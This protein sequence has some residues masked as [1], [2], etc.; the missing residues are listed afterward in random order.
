MKVRVASAGTGKTASLV[1]RYL[2][3]IAAG[4][5]LRRIAGVT[6]T[7]KAADELQVRVGWAMDEVLATGKHLSFRADDFEQERFLEAQRE[8]SG[9][10]ISTIHGFM[11][12]C[13]RLAAPILH[14]DP[15]FSMLGDWEARALF[16]EEW[17][18]LRYLAA[19]PSHPLHTVASE[20]LTEP[21]LHLFGKRSLVEQYQAAEGE[22]NEVLLKVYQTVYSAYEARLGG[23]LLSP[24]EVERR[25]IELTRKPKAMERVLER[26]HILL[27]DEYQDV[28]PLQGEFFEA[29][30][31]EGLPIEVVGDP[32]QSIYAFRNADVAVF[33]KAM[34]EGQA[35]EPL[36]QTY[37]HSQTLVRFLNRLS[38][39]L[40]QDG[41]GF[42]IEEAPEVQGI[43]DERGKLEIHWVEGEA[44]LDEMREQE[45]WI[46]AQRLRNLPSEVDYSDI[47][48]LVR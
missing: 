31:R 47:A 48:V 29:L 8:L 25:A 36:A 21:L 14:L 2:D 41:L 6:F 4:T 26:V 11:G 42:G 30:E 3:L 10:T 37:R 18:S 32:K 44:T 1:L 12:Q 7:R 40:A 35:V 34:S 28:N 38:D 43:R 27:V 45:A 39:A 20:A 46:L 5:P 15:D 24:S 17:T 19:D 23:N 33:R 16:E 13:L 22:A 9:A